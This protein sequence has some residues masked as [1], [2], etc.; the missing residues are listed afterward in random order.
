MHCL[1][2]GNRARVDEKL[3]PRKRNQV[4]IYANRF[5]DSFLSLPEASQFLEELWKS[6]ITSLV[7]F[8]VRLDAVV[9]S[10]TWSR[11]VKQTKHEKNI[12]KPNP[13]RW[14]SCG[15]IVLQV[16]EDL[17]KCRTK[18]FSSRVHALNACDAI[19]RLR[20]RTNLLNSWR[21]CT[22]SWFYAGC[23]KPPKSFLPAHAVHL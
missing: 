5:I 9:L 2:P 22:D 16:Y 23:S 11:V 6:S 1:N 14:T 15:L 7:D 12:L 20:L 4:T 17:R 10:E 3:V 13:N 8:R 19:S 21:T 18:C